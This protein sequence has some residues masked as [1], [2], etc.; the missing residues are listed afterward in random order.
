M[1]LILLLHMKGLL[2][3]HVM[4]SGKQILALV[5]PKSWKYTV[6]VEAHNKLGHQGN[7]H[8]YCLI[9]KAILLEGHE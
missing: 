1:N 8:M 2:Y 3:K 4:D 9:K 5:I 7:S 6:L